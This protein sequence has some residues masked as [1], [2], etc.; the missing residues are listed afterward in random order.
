MLQFALCLGSMLL[1]TSNKKTQ[2]YDIICNSN[3]I[4]NRLKVSQ[5]KIWPF[6]RILFWHYQK[7]S[8]QYQMVLLVLPMPIKPEDGQQPHLIRISSLILQVIAIADT[9]CI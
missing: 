1:S 4:C 2:G 5:M 6:V 7:E 8:K 9:K 3:T